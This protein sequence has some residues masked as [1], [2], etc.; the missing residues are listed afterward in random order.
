MKVN[1]LSDQPI[2][3]FLGYYYLF[4][5]V[6]VDAW[7]H[8]AEVRMR[9]HS[10]KGAAIRSSVSDS[11][12]QVKAIRAT[13]RVH[14]HWSSP[15]LRS[16]RVGFSYVTRA[17]INDWQWR[18]VSFRCERRAMHR[19]FRGLCLSAVSISGLHR[20]VAGAVSH[21][22]PTAAARVRAVADRAALMQVLC[23][24]SGFP[25]HSFIPPIV[26]NHYHVSSRAGTISQ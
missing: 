22:L 26:D 17:F 12:S 4:R 13:P 2:A 19:V 15:T 16:L 8:Q 6:P 11:G 14:E 3:V 24:Y 1:C 18:H 5:S 9:F 23:E 10:D 21:R 25:C 20:P 7:V